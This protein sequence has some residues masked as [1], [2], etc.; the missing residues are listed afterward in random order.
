MK[1]PYGISDFKEI[2]LDNYFYCDRSA[3][4]KHLECDKHQLFLR[5]RRFGKSLLLSML[6]NYYDVAKKDRFD[7][8]FGHLEIGKDPTPLHNSYFI[9]KWDFSCIDS[10]GSVDQIRKSIYD[11][12]NNSIKRFIMHYK[13]YELPQIDIDPANALSSIQSLANAVEFMDISIF[14]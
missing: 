9:L 4:I 11:H 6:E 12:I 3:K 14:L 10:S 7:E 5:P 8:L 1:F 13:N 2:I